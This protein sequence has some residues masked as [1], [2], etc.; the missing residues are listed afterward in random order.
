MY[1]EINTSVIVMASLRTSKVNYYIEFQIQ[2]LVLFV[3]L[4]RGQV[5]SE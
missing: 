3:I 5:I 1:R 2:V 4:K